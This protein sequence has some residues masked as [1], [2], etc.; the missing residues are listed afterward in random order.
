M[1]VAALDLEW[2][3]LAACRG[4]SY[5]EMVPEDSAADGG[6][7]NYCIHCPVIERCLKEAI[8]TDTRNGIRGGL[9]ETQRLPLHL[10]RER[11]L[12]SVPKPPPQWRLDRILSAESELELRD[13]ADEPGQAGSRKYR[14]K[15]GELYSSG[16]SI[17]QLLRAGAPNDRMIWRGIR[18]YRLSLEEEVKFATCES[19]DSSI[20]NARKQQMVKRAHR[21]YSGLAQSA[22]SAAARSYW[23]KQANDT[24]S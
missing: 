11:E 13:L 2:R 8:D 16:V 4:A 3:T 9:S 24:L 12:A 5:E 6:V 22:P 14:M 7:R 19:S 1:S 23:Q 10:D 17:T 15:L 18:E 21:N 20:Y